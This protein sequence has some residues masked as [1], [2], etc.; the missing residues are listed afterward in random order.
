VKA[1]SINPPLH[2]LSIV[3]QSTS[4]YSAKFIKSPLDIKYAP[5]IAATAEKAQQDPQ[6]P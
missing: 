1:L 5:S 3:S 2:P 4:Y 6:R